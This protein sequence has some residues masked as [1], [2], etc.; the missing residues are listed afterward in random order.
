M[1]SQ[2]CELIPTFLLPSALE[3]NLQDSRAESCNRAASKRS[4]ESRRVPMFSKWQLLGI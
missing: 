1:S 3:I 4:R 2:N